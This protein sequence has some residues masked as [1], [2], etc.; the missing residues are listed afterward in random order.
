MYACSIGT[1]R[2]MKT[3]RGRHKDGYVVIKL[4]IKPESGI[5]LAKQVEKIK[6]IRI[7]IGSRLDRLPCRACR[8]AHFT[9]KCAQCLLFSARHGNRS[10]SLS[11]STIPL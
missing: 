7:F 1:A 3:L 11:R 4:F 2:F 6:G 9:A 5:N 10:S 8:G